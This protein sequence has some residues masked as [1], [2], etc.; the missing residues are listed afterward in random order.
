MLRIVLFSAFIFILAYNRSVAFYLRDLT[1]V[2]FNKTLR[3]NVFVLIVYYTSGCG[4]CEEFLPDFEH[5]GGKAIKNKPPILFAKVNCAKSF[6]KKLC[7]DITGIPV[8]KFY[9]YGRYADDFQFKDKNYMHKYAAKFVKPE[10]EEINSKEQYVDF[11]VSTSYAVIG[12]FPLP[13]RLKEAYLN[14]TNLMYGRF[15]YAQTSVKEVL[16]YQNVRRGIVVYKA[17]YM[18]NEYEEDF[19]VYNGEPD[20]DKIKDFILRNFHG[21]V[22]F[23][24]PHNKDEFYVPLLTVFYDFNFKKNA[25]KSKSIRKILLSVANEYRNYLNFAMSVTDDWGGLLKKFGIS[26]LP[27]GYDTPIT[28]AIDI[29]ERKYIME[30][31][32]SRSNLSDFVRGFVEKTL[33]PFVRSGLIPVKNDGLIM[34]LVAKNLEDVAFNVGRDTLLYI[35][36]PDCGVCQVMMKE[37]ENLAE[38]LRGEDI[39]LCKID[40]VINDLP[41]L[42]KPIGYP[43]VFYLQKNK[44]HKPVMFFGGPN[45]HD[46]IIFVTRYS[47]DDL[48]RFDRNGNRKLEKIEL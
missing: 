2:N 3:E 20:L 18:R 44:K 25:A 14:V 36:N 47:S 39:L 32:Y 48:K 22:G 37:M 33:K 5:A 27:D 7:V 45:F 43:T 8:M 26:H 31:E 6:S 42:V 11:L 4:P 10:V 15:D 21:L 34:E 29:Y 23:R 19:S 41:K 46:L 28:T 24:R 12:F 38:E 9:K 17:D 1:E 13:C 40:G 30:E 16:D 35:Y